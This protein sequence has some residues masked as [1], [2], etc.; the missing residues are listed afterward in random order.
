MIMMRSALPRALL[1]SHITLDKLGLTNKELSS[2]S[3]NPKNA[4]YSA[5]NE[6][7]ESSDKSN[8]AIE[9]RLDQVKEGCDKGGNKLIN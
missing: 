5:Y 6:I 7:E 9:N 4:A 8:D 1:V 2:F 3:N